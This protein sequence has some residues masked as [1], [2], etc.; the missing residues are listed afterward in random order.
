MPVCAAAWVSH[1][2]SA[3]RVMFTAE[4]MPAD[5]DSSFASA[6]GGAGRATRVSAP[7]NRK[8]QNKNPVMT[9]NTNRPST[10]RRFR[11]SM[12]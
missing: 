2:A 12:D 10:A 7:E 6:R 3:L 11:R 4:V 8:A 9:Q 1:S 5:S